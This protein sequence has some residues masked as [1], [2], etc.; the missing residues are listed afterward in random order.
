MEPRAMQATRR[1]PH[2]RASRNTHMARSPLLR[3]RR[4][5]DTTTHGRMGQGLN[6]PCAAIGT[7]TCQPDVR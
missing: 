6:N 4:M 5:G 3:L 1:C 2:S 7:A